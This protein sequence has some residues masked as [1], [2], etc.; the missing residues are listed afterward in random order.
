MHFRRRKLAI[1]G[2]FLLLLATMASAQSSP[3]DSEPVIPDPLPSAPVPLTDSVDACYGQEGAAFG[4][5]VAY[6]E[7]LDC[8]GSNPLS[9]PKACAVLE[10]IYAQVTHSV[11]PCLCPCVNEAEDFV[12]ALNGDFGLDECFFF[13]EEGVSNSTFI[14]T[15][16]GRFFGGENFQDEIGFCG[17][18]FGTGDT[19]FIDPAAADKCVVLVER[20]AEDADLQ[21]IPPN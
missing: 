15:D 21:C 14:S 19:L 17:F 1:L 11:P 9:T 13:G 16:D 20:A 6:C 12:E 3:S 7:A 2:S 10:R 4:L 18:A 5:C 8:D